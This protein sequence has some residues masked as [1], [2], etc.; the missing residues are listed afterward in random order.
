MTLLDLV[1]F[2]E[3]VLK[4]ALRALP[5]SWLAPLAVYVGFA[6]DPASASFGALISFY[7]ESGLLWIGAVLL[8]GGLLEALAFGPVRRAAVLDAAR[9]LPRVADRRPVMG[10]WRG[11]H[12]QDN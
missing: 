5:Y 10:Y 12:R 3:D 1:V 9:R 6:A 2:S 11:S 8:A 7:R 4:G